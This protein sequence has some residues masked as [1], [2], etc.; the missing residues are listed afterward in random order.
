MWVLYLMGE[1]KN[2]KWELNAHLFSSLDLNESEPLDLMVA[3][4]SFWET[5]GGQEKIDC[6][7][8]FFTS[9]LEKGGWGLEKNS[10]GEIC[11]SKLKGWFLGKVGHKNQGIEDNRRYS[12]NNI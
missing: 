8:S 3:Q 6:I 4:N 1:L 7:H 12:A 9:K 11:C 5:K 2:R 10:E